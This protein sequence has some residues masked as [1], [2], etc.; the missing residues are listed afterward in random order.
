VDVYGPAAVET[1]EA[2]GQQ[3]RGLGDACRHLGYILSRPGYLF[4]HHTNLKNRHTNKFCIV[5]PH[6]E[7]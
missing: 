3:E 7:Q 1:R 2:R 4:S 5:I 6:S